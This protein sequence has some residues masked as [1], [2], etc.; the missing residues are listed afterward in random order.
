[1][2]RKKKYR[3]RRNNYYINESNIMDSINT[4][5]NQKYRNRI[6]NIS[7][8]STIDSPKKSLIDNI[9][10]SINKNSLKLTE[11]DFNQN[12]FI[13][14]SFKIK[15]K[16]EKLRNN[17]ENEIINNKDEKELLNIKIKIEGG[18][19]KNLILRNNKDIKETIEYFCKENKI[20]DK[21]IKGI[22]SLI[23]KTLFAIYIVKKREYSKEEIEIINKIKL[24]YK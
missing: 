7:N 3:K 20:D 2:Y 5:E 9:D 14:K 18:E 16:L 10:N 6:N 13:P 23:N 21:Y 15:K 11:E 12:S 22:I 4:I 1:M 24:N 8:E 17:F 19:I